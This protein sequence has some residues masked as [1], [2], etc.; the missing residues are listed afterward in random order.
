[1]LL[2]NTHILK[3][4][5]YMPYL[6]IS[7]SL[8]LIMFLI[9]NIRKRKVGLFYSLITI[10]IITL[11][12]TR[13]IGMLV[14]RENFDEQLY[15]TITTI[16]WDDREHLESEGFKYYDDDDFSI[17]RESQETYREGLFSRSKYFKEVN[18]EL[19]EYD[20]PRVTLSISVKKADKESA[21]EKHYLEPYNDGE[22]YVRQFSSLEHRNFWRRFLGIPNGITRDCIIYCDGYLISIYEQNYDSLN[23]SQAEEFIYNI[24]E[25][26][27]T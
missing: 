22:L 21:I 23:S 4:V 14:T 8:I 5:N 15:S 7:I 16:K 20:P 25:G 12:I 10:L 18:G 26:K 13:A 6:I 3:E 11:G 24:S 19:V 27:N 2:G 17:Y 1:M 9:L